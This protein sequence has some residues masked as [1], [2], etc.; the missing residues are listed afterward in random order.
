MKYNDG[1]KKSIVKRMLLSDTSINEISREIGVC[2]NTLYNWRNKFSN[3]DTIK[4]GNNTPRNWKT[5]EKVKAVLEYGRL[6]ES[7]SG[8]WLRKNGLKSE[9]IKIWEKEFIEM[10]SSNKYKEENKKLKKEKLA[11]E[12]ELNRKEKALAEV[13]ALLVLK[14]K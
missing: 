1:F 5:P 12:R 13:S 11:L 7:E 10:V 3:Q 9:H 8:Q 14:K 2:T 4:A 6:T